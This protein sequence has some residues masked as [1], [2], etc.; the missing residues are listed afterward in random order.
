MRQS[1]KQTL[2]IEDLQGFCHWEE[3]D[4]FGNFFVCLLRIQAAYISRSDYKDATL[5]TSCKKIPP[6]Y[7]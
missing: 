1:D 3:K 6:D 4:I 7:T 5:K 2:T